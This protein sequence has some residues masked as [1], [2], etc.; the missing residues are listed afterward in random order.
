MSPARE[1]IKETK[2]SPEIE[3]KIRNQHECCSNMTLCNIYFNEEKRIFLV[4]RRF[5]IIWIKSLKCAP[6]GIFCLPQYTNAQLW[7]IFLANLWPSNH[8]L[9][10]S[11]VSIKFT[12]TH[13]GQKIERIIFFE[14]F[15]RLDLETFLFFFPTP[16]NRKWCEIETK[17]RSIKKF[18]SSLRNLHVGRINF[19][20]FAW[21][22]RSKKKKKRSK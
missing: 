3:L 1:P 8:V 18:Y 13:A 12:H 2:Y 6:W 14:V 9:L 7:H 4:W 16:S 15:Y 22:F 11:I 21:K 17:N 20:L 19:I 5:L 10:S